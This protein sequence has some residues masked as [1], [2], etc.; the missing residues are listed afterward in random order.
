MAHFQWP[1]Q[2]SPQ[3][4]QIFFFNSLIDY[5]YILMLSRLLS[6]KGDAV[7]VYLSG[8]LAWFCF[9]DQKER[10]GT[11]SQ[12][13]PDS[14][15]PREKKKNSDTENRQYEDHDKDAT[16]SDDTNLFCLTLYLTW[17]G[18][19]QRGCITDAARP[20]SQTPEAVIR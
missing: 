3:M 2:W 6:T 14:L 1:L 20:S 17:G 11:V 4:T 12:P 5:E 13:N 8:F 19:G 18:G 10:N 7:R 16:K 15:A 9:W